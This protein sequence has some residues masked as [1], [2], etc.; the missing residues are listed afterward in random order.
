MEPEPPSMPRERS[1]SNRLLLLLAAA[2]LASY[3]PGYFVLSEYRAVG[4]PAQFHIREFPN[5]VIRT[6]Y[7]PMGWLECQIRRKQVW[8]CIPHG[9]IV[10]FNTWP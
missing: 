10:F 9:D 3:V 8:F 1:W 4:E 5:Y 7:L 6:V 2:M